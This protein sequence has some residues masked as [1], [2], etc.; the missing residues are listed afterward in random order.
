MDQI[1]EKK[2]SGDQAL[3]VIPAPATVS[4]ASSRSGTSITPQAS[5]GT[6]ATCGSPPGSNPDVG[7]T[8][9]YVYALGRLEARFPTLAV[10]KEYRQVVAQYPDETQGKDDDHVR[11]I[12][13]SKPEN[14]YLARQHCWVLTV[15]G[16]DTY[17]VRPRDAQDFDRLVEAIAPPE[18]PHRLTDKVKDIDVLIGVRGPIAPPEMCNGLSVPIVVFDHLYHFDI[19]S[20]LGAIR[21]PE[22]I[23]ADQFEGVAANM[24]LTIIQMADNAGA[25]DEHRALNY[26]AV[27][28]DRIYAN[29]GEALARNTP[30][31]GMDVRSSRLSGTRKIVDVIFSFTSRQTD[32]AEKYFV[33]VDVTEEFPFLVTKMSPYYDR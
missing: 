4:S 2:Q 1:E 20:L 9:S 17:I 16:Q 27:R 28:Y 30:L 5:V 31:T 26:L 13:L 33:R 14:R 12:V 11:Y 6:C 22:A 24:F 23:S 21:R 8:S 3:N 10:E 7:M 15:E 25:M 32:V 29:A 19:D 18:K